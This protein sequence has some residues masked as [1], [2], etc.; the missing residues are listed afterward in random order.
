MW[1]RVNVKNPTLKLGNGTL[2]YR[3]FEGTLVWTLALGDIVLLAEYTTD[4][5]PLLDDY[6]LVF[7]TAGNDTRKFATASFYC[8]G[9]EEVLGQ[10]ALEWKADT[11][12]ALAG[13]TVWKSRV[14]WPPALADEAYSEASEVLPTTL[15]GRLRKA[16]FGP[17]YEY[18]ARRSICDFLDSDP[19][20]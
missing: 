15:L 12:L 18:P 6:F 13:S 20:R 14:V 2:E 1:H 3:S 16:V 10:L 11:K 19:L 4:A 8:D 5:G 7:V 17:R 9:L